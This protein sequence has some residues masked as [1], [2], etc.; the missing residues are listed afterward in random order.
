MLSCS[1]SFFRSR[2]TLA[3]FE[4]RGFSRLKCCFAA[5]DVDLRFGAPPFASEARHSD[6][7]RT[8]HARVDVRRVDLRLTRAQ[9]GFLHR[10]RLAHRPESHLPTFRLDAA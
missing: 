3:S 6:F 2:S 8:Q 10:S 4:L 1:L 5:R 7:F 9:L